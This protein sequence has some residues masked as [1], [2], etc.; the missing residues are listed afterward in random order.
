M[1]D[2]LEL[3]L[4]SVFVGAMCGLHLDVIQQRRLHH[5]VVR[6]L[7]VTWHAALVAPPQRHAAP[8][9][10][11]LRGLRIGPA[12]SRPAREHDGA[13]GLGQQGRHLPC[14]VGRD[15]ELDVGAQD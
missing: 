1:L 7:V 8:V 6:A 11:E 9:G 12:R 10:A 15:D 5:R 3:M 4:L 2:L 14:G 13:H